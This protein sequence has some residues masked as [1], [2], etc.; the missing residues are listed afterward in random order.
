M[1]VLARQL[2]KM[3]REQQ[4]LTQKRQ[5]ALLAHQQEE[6]SVRAEAARHTTAMDAFLEHTSA[7]PMGA[8]AS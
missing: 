3:K 8:V 4:I 6:E 7:K 1:E 2:E 5:Q